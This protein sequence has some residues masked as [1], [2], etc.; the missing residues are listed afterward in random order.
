MNDIKMVLKT[1]TLEFGAEIVADNIFDEVMIRLGN[2]LGV[3]GKNK[4][5]Q[6]GARM[7][8]N[9][10]RDG[11][12]SMVREFIRNNYDSDEDDNFGTKAKKMALWSKGIAQAGMPGSGQ[13]TSLET[14]SLGSMRDI[15]GITNQANK[16]LTEI[17]PGYLA[18]RFA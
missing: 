5:V 3:A 4:T 16:S 18:R 12:Y 2:K 13:N 6:K 8:G 9:I 17:I 14:D 11:G 7:L 15:S 10:N 1:S